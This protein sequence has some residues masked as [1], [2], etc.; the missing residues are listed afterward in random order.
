MKVH[1]PPL[2]ISTK[3]IKHT[4]NLNQTNCSDPVVPQEI[5]IKN[6]IRN[7]PF[8]PQHFWNFHWNFINKL[9]IRI[10]ENQN[11]LRASE[12]F[13]GP[14]SDGRILISF[15]SPKNVTKLEKA[16]VTVRHF[17]FHS[18]FPGIFLLGVSFDTLIPR[19]VGVFEFECGYQE[20]EQNNW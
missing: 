2:R 12:F 8:G 16:S 3:L 20:N 15:V 9:D 5:G 10:S 13:H 7:L 19:C 18:Y 4:Q 6:L 11:F 17:F 14:A 1:C